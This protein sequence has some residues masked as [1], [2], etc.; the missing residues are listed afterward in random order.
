VV[1]TAEEVGTSAFDVAG[2]AEDDARESALDVAA[3][4]DD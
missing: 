3:A 2:A 1:A 4:E